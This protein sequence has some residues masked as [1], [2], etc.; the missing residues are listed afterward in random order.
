MKL[1][2]LLLGSAAAF[3]VVG[4]AQAA[5]LSVAEPVEYVKAC[6][7]F[8]AGYFYLPGSDTCLQ[9][10][11]HVEFRANFHS[12]SF[13]Y[14]G[15]TAHSASWDFQ[16]A[17]SGVYF[18][19]K[20]MTDVGVLEANIGFAGSYAPTASNVTLDGA[21]IKLG[22]LKVGHFGSDY[23]PGGSYVDDFGI[24]NELR[25][26][27]SDSNHVELSFKAGSV[28]LAL[29]IEDPREAFGS[30]L[31]A[32]YSLPLI[33]GNITFGGSNWSG[34][35]SAGYTQLSGGGGGATSSYGV[36]GVLTFNFTPSD[37]LMI[38]GSWG[39]GPFNGAGGGF[40]YNNGWA[41]FASLQHYFSKTLRTDWDFSYG[42]PAGASASNVT[43]IGGDLVWLPYTGFKAKVGA[44]WNSTS[45]TN[46]WAAQVALRRDW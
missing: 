44:T 45:T 46:Y 43:A 8:G 17:G 14:S 13:L 23:R 28:G 42:K 5:D 24:A 2:T 25:P 38:E 39:D 10:T 30:A 31:P 4:G 1:K 11:G 35:V 20:S 27:M 22:S 34:F 19:A 7:A 26:S 33:D 40:G 16:T 18:D 29:G 32:D 9:I 37:N 6:E 12:N 36:S 15:V 21:F 41:A 3:A